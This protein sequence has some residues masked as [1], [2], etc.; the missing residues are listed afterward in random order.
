VLHV[1]WTKFCWFF[2]DYYYILADPNHANTGLQVKPKDR[3]YRTPVLL[4]SE[5]NCFLPTTLTTLGIISRP[6]DFVK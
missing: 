2:Q 5:V 6:M 4:L 3:Y 1:P